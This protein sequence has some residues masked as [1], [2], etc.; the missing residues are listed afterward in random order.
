[1]NN[2]IW[3]KPKTVP[4][5]ATLCAVIMMFTLGAWQ[6]H[7]LEWKQSMIDKLESGA[8]VEPKEL[9]TLKPENWESLE[10]AQ[11]TFSGRPTAAS[12]IHMAARYFRGELG[13]HILVPMQ[14]MDPSRVKDQS[15]QTVLVN[16]GWI[17]ENQKKTFSFGAPESWLVWQPVH[18][19]VRIANRKGWFTPPNNAERNLWFWYDIPA[20][21]KSVG[22]DI[23]PIVIDRLDTQAESHA[24]N[25]TY[26]VGF[27]NHIK[28]RNDHLEYAVTWFAIGCV[29]IILFVAG[30]LRKRENN[31][32]V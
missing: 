7:R 3:V 27:T 4:V 6:L 20:L 15:F 9:S 21:Q 30:H 14:V 2:F 10:F 23:L 22:T 17:P 28:L 19:M 18:G 26:P 31:L 24:I 13:Y 1:M 11:V 16:M 29:A 8:V 25:M 12:P 5:I 32:P